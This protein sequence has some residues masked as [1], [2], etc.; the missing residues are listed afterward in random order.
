MSRR[1]ERIPNRL[2][3]EHGAN[4]EPDPTPQGHDPRQ[5]EELDAQPKEAPRKPLLYNFKTVY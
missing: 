4:S 1:R 5:N 2:C 3:A